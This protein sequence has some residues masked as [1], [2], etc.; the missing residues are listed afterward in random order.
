MSAAAPAATATALELF[1]KFLDSYN[2]LD[3]IPKYLDQFLNE[4]MP[5]EEFSRASD[6]CGF[7]LCR[8]GKPKAG[9]LK[10]WEYQDV[11][12][13]LKTGY[14]LN[15]TEMLGPEELF[16]LPGFKQRPRR[17]ALPWEHVPH[18][19]APHDFRILRLRRRILERPE[20]TPLETPPRL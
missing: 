1:R 10:K 18:S 6:V 4:Q 5:R 12:L 19:I 16:L 13:P 11:R 2:D 14:L 8:F 17:G 15:L 3:A 20:L 9:R 7:N